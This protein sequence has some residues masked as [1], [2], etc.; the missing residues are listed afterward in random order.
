MGG[1]AAAE[2]AGDDDAVPVDAASVDA[3]PVDAAP[4]DAAPVS[5][6][7]GAVIECRGD[8]RAM[9]RAQG[10]AC[11][12]EL[13]RIE[14]VLLAIALPQ[15]RLAGAIGRL[16]PPL[17]AALGRVGRRLMTPDLVRLHPEQLERMIGIAEGGGIPIHRL[18]VGPMVELTLNRAAYTTPPPAACTAVAVTGRRSATGEAIIAKNF[19]YPPASNALHLTRRSRPGGAR[20]GSLEVTKAPLTGSHDGVNEHGL[21]VAYNYGH[22]RGRARARIS[23]SVLVQDLLETCRTVEEALA[24]LGS[25]PRSGGALLMLADATGD[26]ASVELAPDFMAV[27][28]GDALVHANH[29]LTDEMAPRD[30]PHDAVLPRWIWPAELRGR[31]VHESSER[32]QERAESL[33]SDLGAARPEELARILA[34]HGEA[35][36][37]GDDHTVCRHGPYYSTTCAVVL[38]PRQRAMSVLVGS[39]CTGRFTDLSL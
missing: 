9:G 27:R 18:F 22:F 16:T 33:L 15:N 2:G 35:A 14:Q 26:L 32:R 8:H 5:V 11:R 28:R 31:R 29:A 21:A 38:R 19:D 17:T 37:G 36:R 25:R 6:A 7:A 34:D 39:P 1:E 13:G 24:A 4:V 30:V 3:V 12:A 20:V 10:A 23:I